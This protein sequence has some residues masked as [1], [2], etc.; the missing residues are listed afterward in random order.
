[1]KRAGKQS[2]PPHVLKAVEEKARTRRLD[3]RAFFWAEVA[4]V[5]TGVGG[6]KSHGRCLPDELD[7]V[8]PELVKGAEG[9]D[10][11]VRDDDA[12][13]RRLA[14]AYDDVPVTVDD[15]L[16]DTGAVP[17]VTPLPPGPKG[18]DE[19]MRHPLMT[20]PPCD[21]LRTNVRERCRFASLTPIQRHAVPLA[22]EGRD[23]IAS[24][25][26]GSGKTAAYLIPAIAAILANQND[27]DS[28]DSTMDDDDSMDEE[29]A[30]GAESADVD[31]SSVVST[32]AGYGRRRKGGAGT[33]ELDE[34]SEQS[35]FLFDDESEIDDQMPVEE[36]TQMMP[37]LSVEDE[38]DALNPP[39]K[40][41]PARPRCVVLVPTRELA[42][43]VTTQARRL[44]LFTGLKV[45]LLH[46]G[47]SVK[48][49]L[50]QLAQGPDILVATPGRLLTCAKD[51]PYLNLT[52]VGVLVVDEADQM[53]D[54]GF[55]PQMREI[56][57][58]GCGVP[59]PR[60]PVRSPGGAIKGRQSLLFSATFP[61][62]VQRLAAQ[63]VMA[64]GQGRGIYGNI[65]DGGESLFIFVRAISMT[66]V[67]FFYFLFTG[68]APQPA[69]VS[70]GKIGGAAAGNIT[71]HVIQS[72]HLREAKMDLLLALLKASPSE[73]R[74]LVFVA[75]KRDAS[76]VRQ[77]LQLAAEADERAARAAAALAGVNG[78]TQGA[79]SGADTAV[80]AP[81]L[82]MYSSDEL[83]GDC[84]QGA[85]TRALDAFTSGDVRILVATDVASRG[86]DLPEIGHVINFDLPI[87]GRDFDSYVHRIGRTA[88]AG[89]SGRATSFYVPG[90]GGSGNGPV[91]RALIETMTETNQV[92]PEWFASLPDARG[93]PP[94]GKGYMRVGR[95]RGTGRGRGRY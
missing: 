42:H 31:A 73:E 1:M 26:T 27:D 70:V 29:G 75:G 72:D 67:V 22:F 92:I 39:G 91:W 81:D 82:R 79:E 33:P 8:F 80:A 68:V 77:Q 60:S 76:W 14:E 10:T 65:V 63:L 94:G 66:D 34:L 84:S 85:R 16:A 47:Q 11:A 38:L 18:V 86:L 52:R 30:E 87:D 95:G 13:V 93:P 51:E 55:E 43:Q 24:A 45:A 53:L 56:L 49:Q 88:R 48:P 9:A 41:T 74:T 54:M 89:R 78:L 6:A 35:G 19:L 61:P 37:V 17:P 36:E 3:E 59:P 25:A 5:E 44:C 12:T 46:G 15:P 2:L 28:I 83:H 62:N 57:V 90:F 4:A 21:E 20:E 71:Q 58:G 23:I 69:K 50:E 40:R 32:G 7:D 64:P